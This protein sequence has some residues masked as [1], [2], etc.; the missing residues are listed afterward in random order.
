MN[1]CSFTRLL[2]A[3]LLLATSA[4]QK[5]IDL[6]LKAA[7]PRLMIEG[8]LAD[9]GQ[10]CTVLLSRS[11]TYTDT[12]T[13]PPVSGA[14]VTLSDDAGGFETLAATRTPGRYQGR[15]L[16]GQPGRRYT[17]RVE[18]DGETYVAT[19]TL[20]VAV[21][22]TGLRAEKSSFGGDNI[23]LIPEFQDPAGVRNFY[24]FRQYR[25]GRLNKTVFLQDDELTDGKANSRPLFARNADEADDILVGDSVRVDMQCV[26]AGVHGYLAT[27]SQ[28]L[29]GGSS[30]A[31]ANPTSNFSGHVL[32]YFS[33]HTLR[34]RSL[35]VPA[36]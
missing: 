23:Q 22:L 15:T 4:C 9:D 18:V 31:P 12:N 10:P 36:L 14:L 1:T 11:T 30:A 16:T 29:Q 27:L 20:P 5:V 17:L 33:A 24:L 32:G 26:D 3:G 7:A 13:F 25:N 8:N 19:A 2:A 21:P 34:R 35:V 28:I 6:D